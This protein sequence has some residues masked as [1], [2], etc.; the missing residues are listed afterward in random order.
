MVSVSRKALLKRALMV[1]IIL[2]I[3]FVNLSLLYYILVNTVFRDTILPNISINNF[4]VGLEKGSDIR[5]VL[6][7]KDVVDYPKIEGTLDGVEFFIPVNDLQIQLPIDEAVNYGKGANILQ[8][9]SEGIS[10]VDGVKLKG[11]FEYSQAR[12]LKHLPINL[13]SEFPSQIV[14]QTIFCRDDQYNVEVDSEYLDTEFRNSVLN[15]TLLNLEIAKLVPNKDD[16]RLIQ[17]CQQQATSFTTLESQVLDIIQQSSL[18]VELLYEYKLNEIGEPYFALAQPDYLR[19]KLNDYHQRSQIIPNAVN[20]KFK[21]NDVFI[22]GSYQ[23]GKQLNVE[24]TFINF[25]NWNGQSSDSILQYDVVELLGFEGKNV[26]D[27]TK[28]AGVGK[29]RL[30]LKVDGARNPS[31]SNAE[32]GLMLINEVK[33]LPNEQFSYIDEVKLSQ[34]SFANEYSIGYGTC[35]STTTI[36]RAALEGGFPIDERHSHSFSVESYSWG[37]PYNFVDAA[38]YPDP[39]LDFR[40]TNDLDYPVLMVVKLYDE[41]DYRYH[42]VEIRTDSS[43]PD[44]R[45]EFGNWE[46]I[47]KYSEKSFTGQFT[48]KVTGKNGEL[49]R[50]DKFVSRYR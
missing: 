14:D 17:L 30:L 1:S 8:V 24:K 26:Y 7:A 18:S 41:G 46:Y 47:D 34:R 27:F 48:R 35:N 40:F 9:I 21:G 6:G 23:K 45:V 4:E 2:F 20:Y 12:L 22:L 31:I 5:G 33:V 19:E 10:T 39:R 38:Y 43:V 42:T 37:Y 32:G 36:F 29:T 11:D 13:Q 44:R 50:E 49:I 25:V 15:G 3:T 16:Y 28:I